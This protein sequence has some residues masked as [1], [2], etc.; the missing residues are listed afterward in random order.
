M[1]RQNAFNRLSRG[2]DLLREYNLGALHL[3]EGQNTN[4][5]QQSLEDESEAKHRSPDVRATRAAERPKDRAADFLIAASNT[6]RIPFIVTGTFDMVQKMGAKFSAGR[7]LAGS[8]CEAWR[9]YDPP[10]TGTEEEED[11][12]DLLEVLFGFQVTRH[13]TKLTM[14]IKLLFSELTQGFADIAVKLFIACQEDAIVTGTER[15]TEEQIRRVFKANFVMVEGV[16]L[17]LKAGDPT[18]LSK[19]PDL[20]AKNISR[21]RKA[22][23]ANA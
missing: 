8:G 23:Q 9:A 12:N 20:Y 18:V 6:A 1:H 14:Q 17:A 21:K 10:G 16:L 11:L 5:G 22:A 15:M 19:F 13:T 7:R 3:D 2:F 4:K